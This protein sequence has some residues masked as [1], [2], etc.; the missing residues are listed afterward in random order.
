[1]PRGPRSSLAGRRV[2]LT[3][4]AGSD[5]TL[6]N[7]LRVTGAQ[8][9]VLPLLEIV[10]L[11][12]GEDIE[13]AF[14]RPQRFDVW[15]FTSRNAVNLAADH[16]EARG[17]RAG[18]LVAPI[19]CVGGATAE[20]ARARGFARL[21]VPPEVHDAVALA[22]AWLRRGAG[23]RGPRGQCALFPCARGA[24]RGLPTHLRDAGVDLHEVP[25]YETRP[26][27]PDPR[28]LREALRSD[29]ILVASPSA[30]RALAALAG[31]A[32][33]TLISAI[34]ER[35]ATAL[36]ESGIP[37]ALVAPRPEAHAWVRALEET[38]RDI[39]G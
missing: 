22:E 33:A 26:L 21:W 32:A 28:A 13:D 35:T 9:Q 30:A 6:S 18:G 38:F 2:V 37:A 25:L 12:A 8:V 17:V 31:G 29:V 19:V 23:S 24:A 39:R 36:A 20:A 1:M 16:L 3:R 15:F 14:G 10:P 27:T 4:P 11:P 5:D 34:G 7:A